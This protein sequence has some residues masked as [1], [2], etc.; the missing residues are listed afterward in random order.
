MQKRDRHAAF[1]DAVGRG[2]QG[3]LFRGVVLLHREI[4]QKKAVMPLTT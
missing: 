2:K 4:H 1:N 3:L